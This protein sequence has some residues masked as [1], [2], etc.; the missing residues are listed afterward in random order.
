MSSDRDEH[1]AGGTNGTDRPDVDAEPDQESESTGQFTIDYTPPAWYMQGME[2][3][4]EQDDFP[5]LPP[6]PPAPSVA[7]SAQGG[8]PA[9]GRLENGSEGTDAWLSGADQ[10]SAAV[11]PLD[12]AEP[13]T[14]DGWRS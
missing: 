14:S 10:G 6:E 3:A 4:T 8:E 2:P 1:R 7:E 5:I 12:P 13:T 11:S 9:S